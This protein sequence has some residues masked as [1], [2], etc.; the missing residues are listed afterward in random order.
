MFKL[1]TFFGDEAE[2]TMVEIWNATK[3]PWTETRPGITDNP[4]VTLVGTQEA[5]YLASGGLMLS[6]HEAA[7]QGTKL[8]QQDARDAMADF[9]KKA[10]IVAVEGN[11]Q[12]NAEEGKLKSLGLPLA[13]PHAAA[14]RMDQP[15]IISTD[16]VKGASGHETIVFKKSAKFC[17]GTWVRLTNLTTNTVKTLHQREKE[18][19]DLA[20]LIP[21]N[22]YSVEVA[23]DGTDPLI[24]WSAPKTFWAE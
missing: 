22:Q 23:Y 7:P 13:K 14:G 15:L 1:T 19:F 6:T 10:G 18:R 12:C 16:P 17:H 11:L 2:S 9:K 24:V 3:L 8:Q 20:D 21:R 4:N 5:D